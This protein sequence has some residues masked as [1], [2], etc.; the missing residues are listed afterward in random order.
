MARRPDRISGSSATS[1]DRSRR[2]CSRMAGN[3][4]FM[5]AIFPNMARSSSVDIVARSDG[6]ERGRAGGAAKPCRRI[7]QRRARQIVQ[8]E[9][10]D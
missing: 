10:C 7:L 3:I 5:A 4:C 9:S 8:A 6:I 2:A 1:L